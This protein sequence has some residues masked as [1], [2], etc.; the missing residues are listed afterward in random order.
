[1][2]NLTNFKYVDEFAD[3][4]IN[5]KG[6][7]IS[8]KFNKI[9]ILKQHTD[10]RGYLRCN[11]H[12]NGIKYPQKIHRLVLETFRGKPRDGEECRHLNGIKTDNRLE[13]LW[14]GTPKEN[15]RDRR[16][17]GDQP[18][19]ERSGKSKLN[20]VAVKVIRYLYNNGVSMKKLSVVYKLD[21]SNIFKCI[22]G[23]NWGYIKYGLE[24]NGDRN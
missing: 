24:N 15:A 23:I 10:S 2:N 16:K 6:I 22:K 12:K 7:I 3:Y 1:M 4:L 21:I 9:K 8:R 13:N 20:E 17:H 5:D 11:L 14:W 18:M 19:G